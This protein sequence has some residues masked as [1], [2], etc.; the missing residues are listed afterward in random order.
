[1]AFKDDVECLV[2][3]FV[4]VHIFGRCEESLGGCAMRVEV[5]NCWFVL[6]TLGQSV[7]V[8]DVFPA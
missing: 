2:V 8:A 7:D 1:M 6:G 5:G 4:P 3:K